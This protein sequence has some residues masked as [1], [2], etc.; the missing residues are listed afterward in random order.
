MPQQP[1]PQETGVLDPRQLSVPLLV[2][3]PI[4]AVIVSG[5]VWGARKLDQTAADIAAIRAALPALWSVADQREWSYQLGRD[6]PGLKV[7]DVDAVK[8]KISK[9]QK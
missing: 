4:V 5:A 3:V 1:A 6:L 9:N 2:V 8:D 7:P